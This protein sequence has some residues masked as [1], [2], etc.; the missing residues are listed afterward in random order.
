[1]LV[2]IQ[3]TVSSIALE[4]K[5]LKKELTDLKTYIQKKGQRT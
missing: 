4:N 3:I 5:Q 2:D 1:M